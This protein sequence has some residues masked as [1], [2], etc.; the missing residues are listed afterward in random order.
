[1]PEEMRLVTHLRKQTSVRWWTADGTKQTSVNRIGQ[2]HRRDGKSP[3]E[4]AHTLRKSYLMAL[5]C[6]NLGLLC[7]GGNELLELELVSVG[8][9]LEC[10]ELRR[11]NVVHRGLVRTI[12]S[13][14]ECCAR[15]VDAMCPA[16]SEDC[17]LLG[18]GDEIVNDQF[19]AE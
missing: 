7:F 6:L 4:D 1:L 13:F 19:N 17:L 10:L 14:S 18:K 2:S 16:A 5:T 9:A 12:I 15:R 3:R 8:Q 11:G